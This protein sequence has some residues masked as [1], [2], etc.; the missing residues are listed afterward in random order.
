M[1]KTSHHVAVKSEAVTGLVTPLPPKR[2]VV[3]R[4]LFVG[5]LPWLAAFLG[6]YVAHRAI[7]SFLLYHTLCF[8]ASV[9]YRHRYGPRE[10]RQMPFRRW[11]QI[12][13]LCA[14][15]CVVT[16]FGVGFLGWLINADHVKRGLVS[17]GIGTSKAALIGLYL[18]F[19][20]VN[21]IAEEFFW[22]GSIYLGLRASGWSSR[23]AGIVSSLLFG[24]WHWLI[25]RFFFSPEMSI[26]ITISIVAVGWA[27]SLLYER[28]RS[29]PLVALAHALG[30]DVPILVALWAAVLR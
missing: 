26:L 29:V 28:A 8:T 4:T 30:A 6:S 17:Q 16:Y 10:H 9:V 23:R 25:V 7:V 3:A 13:V 24:S 5:C 2:R 12:A 11:A 22:R 14:A 15:V 27:F 21:P 18:Y 1:R 20:V 19:A